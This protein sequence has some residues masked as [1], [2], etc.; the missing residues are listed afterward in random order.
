MAVL[1]SVLVADTIHSIAFYYVVHIH[2][3]NVPC[4]VSLQI[5]MES[6]KPVCR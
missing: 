1:C 3:S 4:I 6:Y 5:Q 2:Q